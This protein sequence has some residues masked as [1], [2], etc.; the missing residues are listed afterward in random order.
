M[1]HRIIDMRQKLYDLLTNKFK[2]P[3]DWSHITRQI[4]MVTFNDFFT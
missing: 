4:G 2:T 1:A 3:G